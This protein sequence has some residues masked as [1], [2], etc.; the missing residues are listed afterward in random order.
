MGAK[1]KFARWL[2]AN[3]IPGELCDPHLD[4][5]AIKPLFKLHVRLVE[6]ENH[7]FCNRTCWFCPNSTLDRR[8]QSIDID[9]GLFDR[10]LSDLASIDYDQTLVW[11]RYHE[12]TAAESIYD[13]IA[14]ARQALPKAFLTITSNG[15]YLNP[16]SLKRLEETG[17]DHMHVNVYLPLGKDTH[18]DAAKNEWGKFLKRTGL[19][20]K[21]NTYW[22]DY[23]SLGGTRMKIMAG[24]RT[25]E[26][27]P[28]TTT[29]GGLVQLNYAK[30]YQR[31]SACF[32]PIKHVVIDYNGKGVLCCQVRSDAP[33]HQSA[34]IGDL[35]N[36]DYS[37]FHFYRDL[38]GSRA[39]LLKGG[40]KDGPCAT[41]T[42]NAWGPDT[43][44][45]VG[46]VAKTLQ[47]L[48]GPSQIF[49]RALRKKNRD[50]QYE[51]FE[52]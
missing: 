13:N 36:P 9:P 50:R 48:P 46:L 35:S 22:G 11:A 52:R 47:L 4:I 17:L 20:P 43:V 31:T 27:G 51:D 12:P 26:D 38:A 40:P 19:T 7:S 32:S 8:S 18:S 25:F 21:S 5:E 24:V 42:A 41:C 6:I 33:E 49:D 44:G 16:T 1:T 34:I 15:D 37:L 2:Y 28:G 3:L 45:R 39:A 29:R 30:R 14:K 10:M 23:Y